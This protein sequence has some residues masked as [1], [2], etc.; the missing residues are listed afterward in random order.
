MSYL[1]IDEF[2]LSGHLPYVFG[3]LSDGTFP[4]EV[5]YDDTG[6]IDYTDASSVYDFIIN[7]IHHVVS[8]VECTVDSV[9]YY[10]LGNVYFIDSTAT[11]TAEP[12]AFVVDADAYDAYVLDGDEGDITTVSRKIY[13]GQFPEDSSAKPLDVASLEMK[14][15][16]IEPDPAVD[17]STI[18]DPTE[19]SEDYRY[20]GS[21]T[22]I[23]TYPEDLEDGK[24]TFKSTID[25]H[26]V[27]SQTGD[28][29]VDILGLHYTR[30]L[31][32]IGGNAYVIGNGF[33][34]TELVEDESY[35]PE[36]TG[37]PF[38][39]YIPDVTNLNSDSTTPCYVVVNEEDVL[40]ALS[41]SP[42]TDEVIT[43]NVKVSFIG[44]TPVPPAPTP[45]DTTVTRRADVNTF[46]FEVDSDTSLTT[47]FTF[48]ED[49]ITTVYEVR[50]SDSTTPLLRRI[51]EKIDNT[52]AYVIGNA[53]LCATQIASVSASYTPVDTGELFAIFL[54]DVTIFDP[55]NETTA[56]IVIDPV[57]A[58]SMTAE[59]AIVASHVVT[60]QSYIIEIDDHA[61]E[62]E[63]V[64]G[65]S[66]YRILNE[67]GKTQTIPD[68]DDEKYDT[69]LY[70]QNIIA[71]SIL[72]EQIDVH[73]L[74]AQNMEITGNI[75][76][77]Q[78]AY[79]DDEHEGVFLGFDEDRQ[80]A[81]FGVGSNDWNHVWYKDGK[82]D[83][84][85]DSLKFSSGVDAEEGI[86]LAQE[87]GLIN[88]GEITRLLAQTA[89][90]Q[91]MIDQIQLWVSQASTRY[92]ILNGQDISAYE[93]YEVPTLNNY[94]AAEDFWIWPICAD[95]IYCSDNLICGT[96][97]YAS[98]KWEI[99]HCTSDG[100]Y[101]IFDIDSTQHY[102][103][104][105]MTEAE[106]IANSSFYSAVNI[107]VDEVELVSA[108]NQLETVMSVTK[109]G[110]TVTPGKLFCC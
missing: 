9:R 79:A 33:L 82:V 76:S 14:E 73:N 88:S 12:F 58:E 69:A 95:D 97:D 55:N 43:T 68:L 86:R 110:V 48:E 107:R 61:P 104:R 52:D 20:I 2:E 11:A 93:V 75:H 51:A 108:Q 92:S 67:Y 28:Y 80:S 5:T 31:T 35:D 46:I 25:M 78:K 8:P 37:D 39:I 3:D 6:S 81:S 63:E 70:G 30:S 56:T 71:N 74:M 94:P 16:E 49:E 50:S 72:A 13:F 29:R 77:N 106:Y 103:W 66:L 10:V 38:G 7:G 17:P 32:S 99:A 85:A 22:Y 18:D 44:S 53:S 34:L 59:Y 1:I 54:P 109:D 105:Q 42:N 23:Y 45:T 4:G 90:I 60:D 101:Y 62:S 89:Q 36:D 102:Y 87:A 27:L 96:N 98:H 84:Q 100:A 64:E 41:I 91:Q 83:I 26:E 24:W 19:Y 40:S 47:T 65:D 15:T 21:Y 57:F